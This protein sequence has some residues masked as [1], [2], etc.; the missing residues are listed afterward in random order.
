[1]HTFISINIYLLKQIPLVTDP[2]VL[3]AF[4]SIEMDH[5]DILKAKFTSEDTSKLKSINS[6]NFLSNVQVENA[7]DP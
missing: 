7:L 4:R 1:M 2:N 6:F 3:R 5:S